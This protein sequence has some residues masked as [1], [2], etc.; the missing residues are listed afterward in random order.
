MNPSLEQVRVIHGL[1]PKMP[2]EQVLSIVQ[3]RKNL[4]DEM[5]AKQ[6]KSEADEIIIEQKTRAGLTRIQAVA[7]IARQK[8]HDEALAKDRA[9]R[10]PRLLAIIKEFGLERL[11]ARRVAG[12]EFPG[13]DGSEWQAAVKSAEA[14]QAQPAAVRAADVTPD[15]PRT[16]PKVNRRLKAAGA[17]TP[18]VTTATQPA[19]TAA[20]ASQAAS[21]TLSAETGGAQS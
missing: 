4:L 14:R 18:P 5:L 20:D 7:V 2:D 17:E 15:V 8:A 12:S 21:G 16:S 11:A 1:D 13:L 9:K 6:R 10:L 3:T 19:A